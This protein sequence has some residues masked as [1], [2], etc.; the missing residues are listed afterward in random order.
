MKIIGVIPARYKSSRFPGKPLADILGKP[1]IWWVY[2]NTK[3]VPEF[4]EIYVA[5]DD[6]RIES[7][8]KELGIK[9]LMTSD[10]HPTG[11][12]R[13]AEVAQKIKADLYVNI[14]GDEPLV[15]TSTIQKAILPNEEVTNLMTKI[16]REE[17]LTDP[18]VP[19]VVV[20]NDGEA[21]FLSRL[22]IPYPKSKECVKYY[23]QVCVYCF[24]PEAL[25]NFNKLKRGPAERAEDIE[26]LRFIEN[27]IPVK[28]IEVEQDTVAVDRPSDIGDAIKFIKKEKYQ[29]I[30]FDFD[31]VLVDSFKIKSE[32]FK[33]L[34]EPWGIADKVD[35]REG[36]KSRYEKIKY[37]HKKLLNHDLN[38]KEL[39]DLAEKY[40]KFTLK[41]VIDAP[42]IKG[43]K[44]FL[45][46]NYK[47]IDFYIVSG[48]PQKELEN[49]VKSRKMGKYFKKIYGATAPKDEVFRK[50]ISE[51]NYN[52]SDI[53]YL[54][55]I[56]SDYKNSKKAN[57]K[58]IGI[59]KTNE[60]NPF[61]KE[62]TVFSELGDN[63][64]R[65][66]L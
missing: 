63:I 44:E 18:S 64:W 29:S 27:R 16:K 12:D 1:M 13:I 6:K 47:D 2:K 54:G 48:T 66:D 22:P 36:G 62:V 20:N 49:I 42:W 25:S 50:L 32:A 59:V 10:K 40:S 52:A 57:I 28:M 33:K 19:K 11:T 56:P 14:Q 37:Y 34:F 53:L 4:D 51:N 9:V 24:S 60:T 61:P 3:K 8:C 38:E 55:D 41:A 21:V 17:D 31:G 65:T 39:D 23:K 15:K 45:E 5:T 7:K 43:A 58:F 46:E 30:V 35:I 26:L